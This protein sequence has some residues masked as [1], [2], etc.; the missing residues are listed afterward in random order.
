MVPSIIEPVILLCDNNGAVAQAKEPRSHHRSKHVLRKY[1]LIREFVGNKDVK[2]DR[3]PTD[4][5]IADP[6]T[7][8]LS[9]KKH[10]SHAHSYG[11]RYIGNWL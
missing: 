5:N 6:L 7:K 4:E 2:I 11:I 3:V 8:P 1:H 9:Q 10:D